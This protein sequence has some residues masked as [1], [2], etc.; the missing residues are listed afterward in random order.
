MTGT[1]LSFDEAL[2]ATLSLARTF[3]TR[4]V[5]LPEAAGCVLAEDIVAERPIPPFDRAAMDGYAIR[6]AGQDANCEFRVAGTVLP[7]RSWEGHAQPDE[8]VRIMTGA[9][10][11]APFDTI[12]PFEETDSGPSPGVVRITAAPRKE[13]HVAQEGEDA[14]AGEFLVPAGT[15]LRP[16]HVATLAA[17]GKWEVA[18]QLPPSVAV[19]AT[20]SELKEPWEA[21]EGP[22]IRNGNAHFL[23]AALEGCGIRDVEYL[24]IAPDD[25]EALTAALRRGLE[26]DVL[27]VTGGVSAGDTDLVPG[28]LKACGV[29]QL[30]HRIA[31]Q[32]GKPVFVGATPGGKVAIGLPGNPVA[33]M[34]HFAMLVRPFLL[35]SCGASDCLPKPVWLPLAEGAKNRSGRLKYAAARLDSSGDATFVQEIASHGSGDFV[36][37]VWAEGVF[38]IP[39]GIDHLP[40]G[41]PV[42]FYPVWG[43][44]QYDGNG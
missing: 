38:E 12:V 22:F 20:G 35:R 4:I 2:E 21:A 34:L 42:R 37:S 40:A 26:R 27:I 3:G 23:L 5:R 30:F 39:A 6:W 8:C 28:C 44:L 25:P 29:E 32:P 9:A 43:D 24:G 11:P 36:S 19:L 1:P 13:Q 18:V 17:V 31:V 33:V 14:Q 16:R 10:V 7:G 41:A 15:L